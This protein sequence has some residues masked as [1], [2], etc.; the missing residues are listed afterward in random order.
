[1]NRNGASTYNSIWILWP[2]LT[3]WAR[4]VLE[5]WNY[6]MARWFIFVRAHL[7]FISHIIII[8]IFVVVFV[9]AVAFRW[10]SSVL[11]Q[12]KIWSL[13]LRSSST[14]VA[15]FF[16][17]SYVYRFFCL[18][19]KSKPTRKERKRENNP[20]QRTYKTTKKPT[21]SNIGQVPNESLHFKPVRWT[22]D[23]CL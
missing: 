8:T 19:I 12:F 16:F 18:K 9:V 5:S 7:R 14:V 4:C 2:L 6:L 23:K 17:C 15:L 22:V 21:K 11:S 10:F 3:Y 1:M 20:N 13:S